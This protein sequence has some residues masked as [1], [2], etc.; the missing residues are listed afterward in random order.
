VQLAVVEEHVERTRGCSAA[1]DSVHEEVV[2]TRL[3]SFS[4][5]TT[6]Q[7]TTGHLGGN[8]AVYFDGVRDGGVTARIPSGQ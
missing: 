8:A 6:V 3:D 1:L 4:Q 5:R 2:T 7:W